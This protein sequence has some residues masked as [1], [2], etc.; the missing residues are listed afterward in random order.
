MLPIIL[1]EDYLKT[2]R[3]KQ[4]PRDF[5]RSRGHISPVYAGTFR[6]IRNRLPAAPAEENPV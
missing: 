6:G 4:N 1:Y 3:N 5:E 2:E